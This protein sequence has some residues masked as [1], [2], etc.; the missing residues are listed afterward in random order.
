MGSVVLVGTWRGAAVPTEPV[1][2]TG[3]E[4]QPGREL[5][6]AL[7]RGQGP[8][9]SR[10]R[11]E[12]LPGGRGA[13]LPSPGPPNVSPGGWGEEGAVLPSPG[14]PIVSPRLVISGPFQTV[15][16]ANSQL[17]SVVHFT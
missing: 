4:C 1:E 11:R 17:P 5:G 12:S 16:R 13:V 10:R 3:Q 7:E 14:P 6:T 15:V 8:L 9:G 2:G